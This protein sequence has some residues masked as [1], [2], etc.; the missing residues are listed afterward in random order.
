MPQRRSRW[1]EQQ[2]EAA[3]TELL[4]RWSLSDAVE[5]EVMNHLDRGESI[6]ALERVLEDGS[7]DA[8]ADD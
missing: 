3:V 4:D 1:N 2:A 8:A 7:R 6:Q 5:Q